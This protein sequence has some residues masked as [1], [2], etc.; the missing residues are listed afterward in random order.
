MKMDNNVLVTAGYFQGDSILEEDIINITDSN[1]PFERMENKTVFITGATGLIGSQIVRTLL[2]CRESRGID[3]K[4]IA[5]VRDA[6]KAKR[7]FGEFCSHSGLTI[8]CGDIRDDLL[9]PYP[10]DYIIHGASVTG[11]K[12]FINIPVDT[13]KT[14]V[15]GSI[16]LLE[17][18]KTK[19]TD[20]M[21]FL[22]SLEVYGVTDRGKKYIREEDYG[23]LDPLN[24]RSSYSESKRMVECLCASYVKQYGV[25]VKIAR[26]SQ[27]FGAGVGYHDNRVFAEFAR[28]ILEKK[29]ILLHTRGETVRNYCYTRDAVKA[30]LLIL[31]KGKNGEAYNTANQ[32][33][34]ISIRD[35]AQMLSELYPEAGIKVVYE[36]GNAQALGYNPD[37]KIELDTS[38]LNA[39]GWKAEVGLLEMYRR[40][41]QSMSD[42]QTSELQNK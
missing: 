9:I 6:E 20:S 15:T 39:L 4:V 17:L 16:K 24:V 28:C 11:S 10:I 29:D 7:V 2:Y 33:T 13:I 1:I 30:I 31:L 22:S 18:A 42:R 5:Y 19:K 40:M 21:V 25:P 35:M 32:S 36:L 38:K 37:V 8:Y 27:T 3:I 26:L 23:Y 14:A 12:D 41:L 34:A